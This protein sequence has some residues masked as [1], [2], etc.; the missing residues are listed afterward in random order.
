MKGLVLWLALT[1]AVAAQPLGQGVKE[2]LAQDMELLPARDPQGPA[3]SLG[4]CLQLAFNSH[5]NLAEARSEVLQAEAAVQQ[6]WAL[7]YPTMGLA[8][9]RQWQGTETSSGVL[10]GNLLGLSLTSPASALGVGGALLVNQIGV[11]FGITQTIFDG[12]Q[13]KEQLVGAR[14]GLKSKIFGFQSTGLDQYQQIQEGYADAVEAELIAAADRDSL[15]RAE[16]NR[17]ITVRFYEDGEKARTDVTQAETQVASAEVQL[18]QART[19]VRT[20]RVHLAQVVGVPLASIAN[21]TLDNLLEEPVELPDRD[22]AVRLLEMNP[23]LLA[24]EAGAA[25]N[26]SME[27][28]QWKTLLPT[29][30]GQ[31]GYGVAGFNIPD[32]RFWTVGLQVI[33]PFYQPGVEPSAAKYRAQAEQL[34]HQRDALR[35]TL[36]ETLDTAYAAVE[37]ARQRSA[38]AA[39]QLRLSVQSYWMSY[40]RYRG[41]VAEIT[42][43]IN[44]RGSVGQAQTSYIQALHDA[45]VA[46]GQLAAVLGLVPPGLELPAEDPIQHTVP[47]GLQQ[48]RPGERR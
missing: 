38:A 34:E 33:I 46:Q 2:S 15:L 12:G 37:G 14:E 41:G 7:Y 13:R 19:D 6:V 48:V 25:A 30:T 28:Y 43:L 17:D 20:A 40:K 21:S 26:R 4:R 16:L 9:S 36:L 31:A 27:R 39:R 32:V 8:G 5:P 1:L 35:L 29:V 42:E 23:A 18:A 10:G 24:L 11:A 45:K 3:L 44:A 47:K 22:A